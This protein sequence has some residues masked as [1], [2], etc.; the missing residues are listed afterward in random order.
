MSVTFYYG[1]GS[2]FAWRVWLA[3]EHKQIPYELKSISF[4]DGDLAKPEYHSINP[5]HKVP[6]IIDDGFA[7]YESFAIVE[8][9]EDK[10]ATGD[11]LFPEDVAS[12]ALVRRMMHETDQYVF[13][14][15]RP[16]TEQ[17][18]FT[19]K[20]KWDIVKIERGLTALS[21]ELA[22]WEQAQIGQF[23]VGERMTAADFAL[24][25][26]LALALRLEKKKSDVGIR[27]MIGPKLAR[28][29]Q[30]MSEQ[31]VIRVT[32]PPHWK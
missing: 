27:Q 31:P 26:M 23:L 8:Y 9:L 11:R 7:L 30:N 5:R 1:S 14:A 19:P 10:Y 21:A 18:F 4:S 6:A 13:A 28:W 22:M 2:P 17:L 3:L 16:L 15:M 20:E 25:P 12:R 24:Y 32:W 29:M